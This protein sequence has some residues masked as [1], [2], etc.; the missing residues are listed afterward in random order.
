MIGKWWAKRQAKKRLLEEKDIIHSSS[1]INVS[2]INTL[3]CLAGPYRNLTTLTASIAALHPNCQVLNHA[4]ERILPHREVDFFSDYTSDKWNRFLQYGLRIS[5][6]GERGRTGGSIM[7]SHA[8]DHGNVKDLYQKR[9]GEKPIKDHVKSVLWK[10]GLYLANHLRKHNVDP[11]YLI[12][13]QKRLKFLLPIRNVLDCAVSNKKTTLAYIFNDIDENSSLKD[14]I[15]AVLE[16]HLA[17]FKLQQKMPSHFF[18]FFEH[19]F[20]RE[21]LIAYCH[22]ANIPFDEQWALDVLSIFNMKS[23]YGH[24]QDIIQFYKEE[25]EIKFDDYPEIKTKLLA[26]AAS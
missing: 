7:H 3:V 2:S 21:T 24:D 11:L 13:Q 19:S 6:G 26:F 23:N 17:F 25:V 8:F 16:E 10:E 18:H 1:N 4:H 9:Y 22:F 5:I 15:S 12:K 14:I 20:D